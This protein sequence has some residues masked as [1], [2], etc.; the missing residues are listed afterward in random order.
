[1]MEKKVTRFIKR[2]AHCCLCRRWP[3][4]IEIWIDG[5]IMLA[6]RSCSGKPHTLARLKEIAS[7]EWKLTT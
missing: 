6:C 2:G 7:V 4:P 3:A 1:M 5:R